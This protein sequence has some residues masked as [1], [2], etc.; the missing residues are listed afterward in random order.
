M[1]PSHTVRLWNSVTTK[2]RNGEYKV[3]AKMKLKLENWQR[4]YFKKI[5]H[6]NHVPKYF[7]H[8]E[9]NKYSWNPNPEL[10]KIYGPALKV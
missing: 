1:E 2:M 7:K 10:E 9:S 3:A 8:S 5:G 6:E 4:A